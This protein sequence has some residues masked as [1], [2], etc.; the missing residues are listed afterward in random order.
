MQPFA[1]KFVRH[2]AAVSS[3]RKFSCAMINYRSLEISSYCF[4]S[5][6]PYKRILDMLPYV[7]RVIRLLPPAKFPASSALARFTAKEGPARDG[8]GV[9]AGLQSMHRCTANFACSEG[10]VHPDQL[11]STEL[12]SA[13]SALFQPKCVR[14][15]ISGSRTLIT[16]MKFR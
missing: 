14:E 16:V 12:P 15:V 13:Q 5:G 3:F 10:L 8:D 2:L 7:A 4:T 11:N 1:K 6:I 9:S